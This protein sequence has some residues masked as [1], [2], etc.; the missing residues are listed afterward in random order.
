[1]DVNVKEA[2][3]RIAQ[4]SEGKVVSLAA[5]ISGTIPVFAAPSGTNLHSLKKFVDEF[6]VKPDRRVG[7]DTVQDLESLVEWIKRHADDGTVIFCDTTRTA[8]KMLSIVDYHLPVERD[9]EGGLSGDATARFGKFRALYEF[10]LSV[11]WRA[12]RAVDGQPMGQADFANFLEDRVLDL[13]APDGSTDGEG[14]D[15]SKLP[16]QVA[17]LLAAL[18]G[19]C[20]LPQDIITLS[21]GLDVTANSRTVTRVNVDTGEGA[22]MFESNHVGADKQKI[23][24]PKLF[25]IAI[26]IF[27]RS[28]FHY[29]IP[30][31]IRYRLEGGIKWTF[32]M[33]G[34]DDVIDQAIREAAEHVKEGTAATLFYGVPG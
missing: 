9:E 3:D 12:W 31:R 19:R 22:L 23:S 14:N 29:R 21:K 2:I 16:P 8:P 33:F 15:I 20:A 6:S 27:E 1:M 17:Q 34:A 10:P 26:P 4:L 5:P 7:T 11:Q 24:V 18:G 32:T 13:I 28:P 25:M 30:V